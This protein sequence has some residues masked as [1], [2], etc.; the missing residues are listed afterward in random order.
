MISLD[1]VQLLE[2]KVEAI[3]NKMNE[4]QK[5]NTDLLNQ[6]KELASK[7]AFLTQKLLSFEADQSKI[8][9]GILNALNR[10]D[11]IENNVVKLDSVE[12]ENISFEQTDALNVSNSIAD[13]KVDLQD[14]SVSKEMPVLQDLKNTDTLQDNIVTENIKNTNEGEEDSFNF[15]FGLTFDEN[16][17]DPNNQ[18]LF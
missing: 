3:F 5:Q 8:E 12:N 18:D 11:S 6:N 13:T 2:K 9:K 10:L 7:H 17:E 16:V 15:D 1:Q 4:L 14:N